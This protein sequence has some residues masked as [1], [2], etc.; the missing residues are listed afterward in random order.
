MPHELARCCAL[1]ETRDAV[2]GWTGRAADRL[3]GGTRLPAAEYRSINGV[4]DLTARFL[5]HHF[6]G[7]PV[8]LVGNSFGGHVALRMAIE[9]PDL[10]RLRFI[11]AFGDQ[12]CLCLGNGG[13]ALDQ[14]VY[15]GT[16]FPGGGP[17]RERLRDRIFV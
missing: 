12:S 11:S 5:D 10:V 7:E 9:R 16:Q 17:Q 4:T 6:N 14:S 3:I 13:P 2:Y 15:H 8:M 1:P